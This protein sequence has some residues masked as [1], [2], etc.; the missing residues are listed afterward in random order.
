MKRYSLVLVLITML[1]ATLSC[2]GLGSSGPPRDAIIVSVYVNSAAAG[3]ISE[4][5]ETFNQ[6]GFETSDGHEIW[7][8][9]SVVEAG[10]AV[11]DMPADPPALWI[12]DN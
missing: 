4:A 7:V 2:V 9:V 3:W 11:V 8:E 5:A 12:P 10:R 6:E 1:A